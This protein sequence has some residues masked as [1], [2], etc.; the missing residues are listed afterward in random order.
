MRG[1]V[2]SAGLAGALAGCA[3]VGLGKAPPRAPLSVLSIPL[4]VA[5]A[6]QSVARAPED[7]PRFSLVRGWGLVLATPRVLASLPHELRSVPGRNRAVGECKRQI[8]LGAARYAD[9]KVEA[10]SA[11][12]ERRTGD[13]LYEGLVEMRVFYDF[14]AYYEV[15]QATLRCFFRP[16]GSVVAAEA[17]PVGAKDGSPVSATE[18]PSAPAMT[19]ASRASPEGVSPL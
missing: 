12:K 3:V 6:G 15:R 10:A 19:D 7:M 16:D 18:E 1:V 11:G 14:R 4:Q 17:L 8:E 9:A 2:V 13:G 5:P